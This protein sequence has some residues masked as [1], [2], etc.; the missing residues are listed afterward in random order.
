MLRFAFMNP[1]LFLAGR[2]Y[3]P[4]AALSRTMVRICIAA[5]AL[6]I[7][8]MLLSVC[9]SAGFEKGIRDKIVGFGSHIQICNFD[10]NHSYETAPVN[11]YQPSFA[12]LQHIPGVQHTQ[13]FAIKAGIIKADDQI[14]GVVLKGIGMDFDWSFFSDKIV[15]GSPI[16]LSDTMRSNEVLVSQVTASRLG[17]FL[18][19]TITM[20]FVQDP[21]RVRKFNIAGI[22]ETGFTDFDRTW[23]LCDIGHVQKLN[24]WDSSQV[25]GYEVFVNPFS[26]LDEINETIHYHVGLDLES[27]TIVERYPQVF[28]W[29]GL[30]GINVRVILIL[31]M[32][33]AGMNIISTLLIMILER[34]TMIG[35]V[36]A[37]GM[38]NAAVRKAFL[39][40]A[41]IITAK[42]LLWG[43]IIGLGLCLAQYY[44]HLIPLDQA[45]YY[46]DYVPVEI[47][48][49][50][51]IMLN[52][53]AGI[54]C[55]TVLLLPAMIVSRISPIKALRIG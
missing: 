9:I 22:Y 35:V 11:R 15:E 17:L 44:F 30:V 52:A 25:S 4:Q 49:L 43:N 6:S 10:S 2:I 53:G 21:P 38:R 36:K 39:Y 46:M 42:G 55:F 26:Q 20:Y 14:E 34:M 50:V 1:S 33:V 13:A 29:L 41:M 23:L 51:I 47:D 3:K 12:S 18:H 48:P 37:L 24:G 28:D 45:S 7:V 31:M 19:D 16:R 54:A 40:A 5:I 27:Q 32:L 8:I